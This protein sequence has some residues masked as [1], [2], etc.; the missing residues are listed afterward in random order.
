MANKRDTRIG[1]LDQ[2]QD[3]VRNRTCD[4]GAT[5]LRQSQNRRQP[6]NGIAKRSNRKLHQNRF[7]FQRQLM[8]QHVFARSIRLFQ[9]DINQE[10]DKELLGRSHHSALETGIEQHIS[11]SIVRQPDVPL[12]N[13]RRDIRHHDPRPV[14]EV[15]AHTLTA[16]NDRN[17][18]NS[19][20][21]RFRF[22]IDNRRSHRNLFCRRWNGIHIRHQ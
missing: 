12:S 22:C 1:I 7:P 3:H 10:R 2:R 20:I 19:K 13:L 16:L 18:R 11:R 6:G 4:F 15:E 8:M 9:P 14:I 17:R 21:G 5:F